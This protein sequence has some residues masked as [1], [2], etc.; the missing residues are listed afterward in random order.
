[1]AKHV[2]GSEVHINT[3]AL[4]FSSQGQLLSQ[5]IL[6]IC[7]TATM[8]SS[9][10]PGLGRCPHLW[11]GGRSPGPGN[12]SL[13]NCSVHG[14]GLSAEGAPWIR[15]RLTDL[16][17]FFDMR[18]LQLRGEAVDLDHMCLCEWSGEGSE[19]LLLVIAHF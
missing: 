8:T 2:I 1:M 4:A 3:A 13:S 16:S 6:F 11:C 17:H 10:S 7:L 9:G 12:L 18:L 14:S 5:C 15:Q 19:R